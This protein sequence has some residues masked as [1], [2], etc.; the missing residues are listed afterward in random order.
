MPPMSD[1]DR[2]EELLAACASEPI[3]APG[4]VQ[5]HGALFVVDADGVVRSASANV[6][7]LLAVDAAAAL[8][9]PLV[10]VLGS[11]WA[12]ALAEAE[13]GAIA[14]VSTERGTFECIAAPLATDT[15]SAT[16]FEVE[17]DL[18]AGVAD[19]G[20]LFASLD[21]FHGA[22]SIDG[23][24]AD[25]VATVAQ[26]TGFDRVMCYRFDD[27][28]NGEVVAEEVAA[29][30]DPFAGL[31][32][33]ASDIPAQARAQYAR[34]PLRLIPDADATPSPLL[35]EDESW[36][37]LDISDATLRAVSPIHLQ[38]LRNMGVR[39]SMSVS[40]TVDGRL[41]GI[42]ACHHLS[43]VVRPSHRVRQAVRLVARTT[44]AVLSVLQVAGRTERRLDL[45]RRLDALSEGLRREEQRPALDVLADNAH[46]V[47]A[48]IGATGLAIGTPRDLHRAGDVP[49][50][51]VLAALVERLRVE[52]RP[53]VDEALG[54]T[55]PD[56]PGP[57]GALVLPVAGATDAWVM[58]FRPETAE[59]VRWA[60]EPTKTAD[61]ATG[62]LEPR[63]SFDAYIEEVRGRAVPWSAEERAIAVDLTG[64][65]AEAESLR[66]HREAAMAAQLQKALM[67][68]GFPAARGMR[69]AV[70]YR[71]VSNAPLGGDWYDVF[72]TPSGRSIVAVGDVAGHGFEVAAAMAQLRHALRAYLVRVETFE[73]ALGRLNDLIYTLL[74]GEM[75]TVVLAEVDGLEG[76]VRIANGGHL[77][78]V[79]ASPDA[80]RL[81]EVRGPALGW[82]AGT[83]HPAEAVP[84]APGERLILYSDGLIERRARPIDESL[85]TLVDAARAT[86]HLDV[87]GQAGRLLDTLTEGTD[88]DDDVTVVVVELEPALA[89]A[90]VP[91][92]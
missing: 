55:L 54:S 37:G 79:V 53:I 83:E 88:V 35:S 45:L 24:V 6:A 19:D 80:A 4:A 9:R 78:V 91:T 43:G 75:A 31:R 71:P 85:A 57:G 50:P 41:W 30:V 58:W 67:L 70:R 20:R 5:P 56:R 34:T 10:D 66:A 42:I 2:F 69:G 46:D 60:G 86:A 11:G 40:L 44:S 61:T 47:M 32:F 65:V 72:F 25:A 38:Y 1:A 90:E 29:G 17:P 73:E 3:H 48:L 18:G 64:R 63:S 81:V 76:T 16:L 8:G 87:D 14:I 84:M 92:S 13:D 12:D 51:D 15:G 89:Q 21:A 59:T 28:W 7:A 74:P 49:E 68:E 82:K 62:R 23:L 77:P 39:S 26:L 27:D 52:R 33:P 22:T 36:A